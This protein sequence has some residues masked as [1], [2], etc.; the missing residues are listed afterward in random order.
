MKEHDNTPLTNLSD[1]GEFGLIH[2]LTSD[3]KLVNPG[4]IRGIGD[5]AAVIDSFGKKILVSTDLLTEG[6]HFDLSYT[7]MRHLGYKA[8]IVNFSDIAAMNGKP[9]QLTVGLALSAK[10][11]VEACD[12]FYEGLKMA[13]RNYAVDIVGGDTTSSA[14]GMFISITVIGEAKGEDIVMR[15]T[16]QEG[17]LVCVSGDLGGAYMGLLLLERE[18]KVFLA[19]PH[20]Q[21]D[22]QG[23][24]YIIARQLKPE[25]RLDVVNL[26]ADYHIKPTAMIDISDG[27]ASEILH[28]CND[29]S[30]GC[31][32]YEDKIPVDPATA[33]AARE[34]DM[35]PSVAALHGGEDYELLFTVKQSDYDKIKDL[36]GI[37][38]IGHITDHTSGVGI[39]A[40]DGALHPITAQGWDSFK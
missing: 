17:D 11:T 12:E 18:K 13:C 15:N 6:V 23:N 14:S 30:K 8:A 22:L 36:P 33:I 20:A 9:K 25:A 32:L 27:L 28:I 40:T 38:I 31:R 24:D 35:S 3:I 19:N 1:L 34:F 21:P 10:F 26:F 2:R 5:D 16:A 7:P 39:V 4:T 37:S 29:S